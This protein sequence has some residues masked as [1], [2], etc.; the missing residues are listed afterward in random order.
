MEAQA[1]QPTCNLSA[2]EA[3]TVTPGHT[4]WLECQSHF[5]NKEGIVL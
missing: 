2:Q 3:G 5:K 4:G 1:W